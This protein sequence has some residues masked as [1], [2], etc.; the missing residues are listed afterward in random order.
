MTLISPEPARTRKPEPKVTAAT[1]AGYVAPFLGLVISDALSNSSDG[2]INTPLPQWA[3]V[4]LLPIIPALATFIAAY[5]A[6]HQW[7]VR[8][9]TEGGADRSTSVG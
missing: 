9:R 5:N 1:V 7:R 2:I 3:E 6:K 4:L 8:P